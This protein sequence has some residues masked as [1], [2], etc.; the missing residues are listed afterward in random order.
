ML[1]KSF[2]GQS[3]LGFHKVAYTEWGN[4]VAQPPVICVHGLARNGRDFDKLAG[5]LQERTQV[6]CPDIVGR[7]KSDW[8]SD[9]AYYTY[10]QYMADMT[11][12]IARIGSGQIDWVGTSMGG[13]L[14]MFL[15]AQPNN[16]IRK[17]VVNDVGP[18]IPLAALE[19]IGGYFSL[20][21]EFADE[22]QTERHIRQIYAPFGITDDAD[23]KHMTVNSMRELPNGKFALAY[24]PAIGKA[25]L[26]L[27]ED[28]NFWDVYD[29]IRCPT[30]LLRGVNSDILSAE[31]AQEM[32]RRGPKPQ[33]IEFPNTG[34]APALMNAEQIKIIEEFFS[35]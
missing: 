14:G 1:Q 8:L 27:H 6:V 12:L 4:A 20:V 10:P 31:T 17:M 21:P 23:W 5:A 11:A 33:L 29:R 28:T 15:A 35:A 2:L 13:I 30:L 26:S 34:H 7:G 22:A 19:I 18:F 25:F 9:P 32:T 3:P 24:D 16:P